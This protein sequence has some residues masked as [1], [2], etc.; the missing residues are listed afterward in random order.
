MKT[1]TWLV[2]A[3]V[4]A[5]C[6]GPAQPVAPTQTTSA[7]EIAGQWRGLFD[8]TNCIGQGGD[9]SGRPSAE[10]MLT[11]VPSA[12]G[13]EGVLVLLDNERTTVSL[14]A[15]PSSGDYRFTAAGYH[16][17]TAGTWPVRTAVAAIDLRLDSAAGLIGSMTYTNTTFRSFTRTVRF[18]SA[19]RLPPRDEPGHFHGTWQGYYRTV[20]CS[21]QCQ[22]GA[23][24]YNFP[25]GGHLSMSLS[26]AGTAV[27]GTVMSLPVT[28]VAGAST[29]SAT[30]AALTADACETCWD[31]EG[32]CQTAVR[33]L[34]AQVDKLGRLTGTFEYSF[35][36]YTGREHFRQTM[37]V[38]LVSVTRR[39]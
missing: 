22:V 6:S 35:K 39:W 10:F 25:T 33:N 13:L 36:G 12:G 23:G 1:Q 31:C 9:C 18:R 29:L 3:L 5:A 15:P 20:S 14:S 37:Q 34:S 38:E 11:L 19:L 24:G 28:G 27:I 32:V 16:E 26:E 7:P 21:G 8:V 4:A 30:G 17:A 2:L